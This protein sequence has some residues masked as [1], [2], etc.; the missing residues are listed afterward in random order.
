MTATVSPG[1]IWPFRTPHSKPVGRMSL[2][3]T[4]AS[5]SDPLGTWYK[6]VSANGIRT[7]SACVPSMRLPRIHPPPFAQCEY[8]PFL[9]ASH[10]PHD[11]MHE[12]NTRSPA[13]QPQ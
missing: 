9:Q 8:L 1:L 10:V 12:I 13:W 4:S 3:I 6:L 5:S 7:C 11:V 2:S